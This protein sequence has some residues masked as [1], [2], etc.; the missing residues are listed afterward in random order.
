MSRVSSAMRCALSG[1][2]TSIVRMLWSRSA[3]LM[4]MT[5]RSRDIDSSM[6]RKFSACAAS[7]LSK[8]S[9][10]SLVTPSTSDA[11]SLPQCFSTSASDTSVSSTTSCSNAAHASVVSSRFSSRS[12][13]IRHTSTACEMYGSPEMRL[14][15]PCACAAN[16]KHAPSRS[17]ST[18]GERSAHA[19]MRAAR[20]SGWGLPVVVDTRPRSERSH[21]LQLQLHARLAVPLVARGNER[22]VRPAGSRELARAIAHAEADRLG[23]AGAVGDAEAH[24][25]AAA[26]TLHA[27]EARV[28]DAEHGLE[29]A[30][31][32]RRHALEPVHELEVTLRDEHV[33]VDL[34]PRHEAVGA[35]AL[36]HERL[37]TL[38]QLGK[39][40]AFDRQPGGEC[41]TA[42][43]EQQIGASVEQPREI[44]SRQAAPRSPAAL[45]VQCHEDRGALEALHEPRSDDADHARVPRLRPEQD[46]RTIRVREFRFDLARRLD[47]RQLVVLATLA[48]VLLEAFGAVARLAGLAREQQAETL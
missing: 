3:S 27:V 25:L 6:R 34:E 7:R 5:R 20:S 12:T 19:A 10:D 32:V 11:T 15:S 35:R 26:D 18:R 24:V 40:A 31:P 39:P 22:E 28:R 8:C 29:V 33:G 48:V 21:A 45:T 17:R 1:R 16:S 4:K 42:V 43:R 14:W 44:E 41:V 37:E 36:A 38:A 9:P 30:E 13:R 46:R 47:Q 2:S 23:A